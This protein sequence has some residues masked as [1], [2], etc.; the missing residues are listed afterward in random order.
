MAKRTAN[1]R[2]SGKGL[3]VAGLWKNCLILRPEPGL[4]RGDEECGAFHGSVLLASKIVRKRLEILS[5]PETPKSGLPMPVL[6]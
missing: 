1:S 4:E 2:C 5:N 3:V 6:T